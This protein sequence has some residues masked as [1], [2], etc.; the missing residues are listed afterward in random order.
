MRDANTARGFTLIE[1]MISVAILAVV[2]SYILQTFSVTQKTYVVVDQ[3]TEAQQNL[4]AAADRIERDVRLAGYMVPAGACAYDRTDGPDTL[5]LSDTD[6]IRTVTG[7]R[8]VDPELIEG[9]LGV[10][11]NVAPGWTAAGN[12]ATVTMPR[13]WL[14]VQADGADFAE[15]GGLIL[16]DRSD[17]NR[18]VACGRITS[19]AGVGPFTLTV[20]MGPSTFTAAMAPPD[21]VAVPAQ[22]YSIALPTAD[23]PSQLLRNGDVLANDV[24]DLQVVFFFDGDNDRVVDPGEVFGDGGT[25]T[26]PPPAATDFTRLVELRINLIATTRSDDPNERFTLMRGQ[27]TAN[28]DPA[29]IIGTDRKRRRL[30]AATVRLRNQG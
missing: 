13:L 6:M 29:S 18:P 4:R 9:D 1:L 17:P 3:V 19:I 27:A 20:D 8:A 5:F 10:E 21:V 30:H 24:E 28:R 25:G 7:L 12:S 14:D 16:V 15:Q 23:T 2:V 11:L 26:Y 22:I